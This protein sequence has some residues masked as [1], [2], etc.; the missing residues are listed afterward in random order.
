MQTIVP[1]T[2]DDEEIF[3]HALIRL[4]YTRNQPN[5]GNSI[6]KVIAYVFS[7]LTILYPVYVVPRKVGPHFSVYHIYTTEDPK[8]VGRALSWG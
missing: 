5:K 3:V 7:L 8:K 2:Q 1:L 6:L 4:K